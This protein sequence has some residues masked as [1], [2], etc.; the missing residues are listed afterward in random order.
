[1]SEP[2]HSV[3]MISYQQR[4][5][6]EAAVRSVRLQDDE[7]WELIAVDDGST[8]GTLAVL[9]QLA[10]SD[11]R[12]HVVPK[13]NTRLPSIARN[14]GLARARGQVVGFLDGDDE[15]TP[16]RLSRIRSGFDACPTATLLFGDYHP[17][18]LPKWDAITT[19]YLAHLG[20]AD[21]YAALGTTGPGGESCIAADALL[22]ALVCEFF[23]AFTL[24]IAVRRSAVER[25]GL[26]FDE[27]LLMAEDHDFIVRALEGA[28]A[29]FV[30][31]V[32]GNWLRQPSTISSKP[33]AK[34]HRDAFEVLHRHLTGLD[35]SHVPSSRLDIVRERLA[36]HAFE[37]GFAESRLGN[38]SDARRAYRSGFAIR[39][40]RRF[41]SAYA[42]ALL[43][44][45][46]GN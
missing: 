35:A 10:E 46:R 8:D 15:Y 26:R 40:E 28:Q 13:E 29:V 41:L 17:Y 32:L 23:G 44:L 18:G 11:P 24:N 16:G 30:R 45:S 7:D 31:E 12:I 42:K 1:M 33:S 19:G 2:Y 14:A 3:V 38:F 5:L 36:Q 20:M 37:W 22:P 25:R 9:Q 4:T 27:S 39:R 6:V 21:R 34:G 43:H